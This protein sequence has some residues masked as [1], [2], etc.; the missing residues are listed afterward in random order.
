MTYLPNFKDLSDVPDT[1]SGHGS[2]ILSVKST[3][4]GLEFKTESDKRVAVDSSAS[5]GYLGSSDA[6]GVLRTSSPLTYT[7]GG[8]YVTIGFDDSAYMKLDQS[9][10]QTIINGFPSYEDGH[11]D[12]TQP[13]QLIDKEYVDG[14][15]ASS[16]WNFFLTNN[17]ADIGG[18]YYMEVDDDGGTIQE[19][20]SSALSAGNDQLLWSFITE[21][22]YPGIDLLSLGIYTATLFL[23]K[24]GTKSVEIYWKL[25]KRDTGGTETE[26][27]T[28]SLTSELTDSRTQYIISAS[29]VEDIEID[30]T[31]RIVLKIY[32]NVGSSGSNPTVTLTMEAD[33]D[34]RIALRVKSTAFKNIFVPYSGAKGNVDLGSHDLATTGDIT[35]GNLNISNWDDAYSKRV[36]T[37]NSPLSFSSN[38]ASFD[39]SSVNLDDMGDVNA[40]SP[41][42]NQVLKWKDS[43][44]AWV[45]EEVDGIYVDRG[46][47]S[48]DDFTISDLTTDGTWRTLNFSSIVPSG[49]KAIVLRVSVKDDATP[50]QIA[51]RK[52]GNTNTK[53]T[54]AISVT[55]TNQEIHACLIVP[56]DSQRRIEY[57]A[58]SATWDQINIVATGYFYGVPPTT[59]DI[60]EIIDHTELSS[61]AT[62]VDFQYNF[63]SDY[64][65]VLVIAEIYQNTGGSC[66]YLM[67]YND[68]TT[69]SNYEI[70][71]FECSGTSKSSSRYAYPYIGSVSNGNRCTIYCWIDLSPGGYGNFKS[72]CS[73]DIDTSSPIYQSRNGGKHTGTLANITKITIKSSATNG[74]GSGSK[75]T[76][77][78]FSV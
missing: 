61:D 72:V 13:H 43:Q 46:D 22:G 66:S 34:S 5:P 52:K 35:G 6:D 57:N 27:M 37:W 78:G 54:Q 47:P 75:F 31:D 10:P 33:Y 49:T 69:D 11:S 59:T 36:D 71:F 53:N 44:S 74:L 28:S 24:S 45:P 15:I 50:K 64:Y 42:N 38:V 30:T 51:F 21:S 7:D 17:S 19:L 65:Q 60:A 76:I 9:S 25:F 73:R 32:A 4:D 23:Y 63:T 3:E 55:T 56:C 41:S 39:A 29:K 20:T 67:Y 77:I 1:Y 62:S 8:N 16:V 58:T 68:D 48:T 2:K 18:Y 70:Q 12:F 40:P 26:L 14:A